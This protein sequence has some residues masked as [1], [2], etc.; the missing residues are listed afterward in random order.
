MAPAGVN[1]LVI[2][3]QQVS[4]ADPRVVRARA[5]ARPDP[6]RRAELRR[7]LV[8][9]G[10]RRR[11]PPLRLPGGVDHLRPDRRRDQGQLRLGRRGHA[12][13][14]GGPDRG[15]DLPAHAL[16]PGLRRPVRA[17]DHRRGPRR[18]LG[19]PAGLLLHPRVPRAG[20]RQP[21]GAA[22]PARRRLL[23]RG[24]PQLV[25]RQ[26]PAQLPV[27]HRGRLR[28]APRPPGTAAAQL[29]LRRNHARSSGTAS[30]PSPARKS[31][32]PS[33]TPAARASRSSGVSSATGRRRCW[34]ARSGQESH[35]AA[36]TG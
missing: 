11:H 3:A 9:P 1:D 13:P 8:H 36:A 22:R 27:R 28:G 34:P 4:P 7:H 6:R 12:R 24:Q 16:Q 15:G 35:D 29:Q 26:P 30:R 21:A 31:S 25:D 5:R 23:H 19:L 32:G 33:A 20:L 10:E 18:R 14:P 17:R 2:G